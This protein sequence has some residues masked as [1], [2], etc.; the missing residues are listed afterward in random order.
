[1]GHEP[2]RL[3]AV[4]GGNSKTL[5]A[6]ADLEGRILA[7]VR[8]EGSDIYGRGSVPVA[9]DALTRTVQDALAEAGAR[10]A[11][12][13]A[14]VFSLAGADWPEDFALLEAELTARLGLAQRPTVVNDAL[15]G[16]R[17]GAPRWEGVA[18]VCGTFNAVG[19]RNR[20]GRVFHLGFWPDRTGGFDLGTEALKAVYRHGLALGPATRLTER[21]LAMFAA[22]DPLALMHAFT[23][24]EGALSPFEVQRLTPVLLDLAAERDDVAHA[25]V[26]RAGRALGE[27][28]RV[29]AARVG[30]ALEGAPVVLTGGVL[31][32]P[33]GVLV[34]AILDRLPGAIPVRP[35]QEPLLGALLLACDEVG[36]ALDAASAASAPP[37]PRA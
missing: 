23:R 12:L 1:M 16:L 15:G 27:Q 24:R 30:L 14:A 25:I 18:V 19:A 3:L 5:A 4:D 11:D 34:A 26:S 9:L 17:V 10:S 13:A 33:A 31:Q 37:S 20:D 32:H 21:A 29:S 35:K 8:G 2:R 6:V 22:R 28:A 7:S 36:L